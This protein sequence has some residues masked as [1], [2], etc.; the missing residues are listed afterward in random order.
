M[1][2]SNRN[3]AITALTALCLNVSFLN[4]ASGQPPPPPAGAAYN[5][6]N[7]ISAKAPDATLAGEG[8]WLLLTLAFSYGI[9]KYIRIGENKPD[10]PY[11]GGLKIE[12]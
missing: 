9:F 8:I 7:N 11:P 6:G 1:K 10:E 2:R 12:N 3:I 5:K 4:S